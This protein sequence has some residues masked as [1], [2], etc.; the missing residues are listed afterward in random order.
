MTFRIIRKWAEPRK[1][2]TGADVAGACC[3][4]EAAFWDGPLSSGQAGKRVT[5]VISDRV[6]YRPDGTPF[7]M[8]NTAPS[9]SYYGQLKKAMGL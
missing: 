5:R 4:Y 6:A 8:M 2:F 3:E 9:V 1:T 7:G